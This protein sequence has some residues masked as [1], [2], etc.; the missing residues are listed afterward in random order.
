ME[1]YFRMKFF[2]DF[3]A[4]L[5]FIGLCIVVWVIVMIKAAIADRKKRREEQDGTN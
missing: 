1:E 4:P 2:M 5:V 3:V